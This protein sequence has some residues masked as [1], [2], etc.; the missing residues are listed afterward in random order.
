VAVE[1]ALSPRPA[2]AKEASPGR[3]WWIEPALTVASYSAFLIY[4]TWS[5]FDQVNVVFPPYVSPFFSLWLGFGLIRV[6]IIGILLPI[7]AVIP[8][9]LRGSC[10]YYRKSYFRSFFWDPPACAIQEL[11]RGKYRGETRFPWVLNNYH[12]YFLILS[13]IVI[14]FL[15]VDVVRAFT[16]HGHFFIGLGSLIMLANVILL[17]LYTFTCHS[18]RYL[19]GG[20]IDSFS[21][22]RFG[23]LWHRVVIVLNQLN[24]RHGFYAWVSMFSVALT[25]VY[26]R[27]L[28]AGIFH[29][30]RWIA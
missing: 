1:A 2:S 9:G 18:F 13:I 14:V 20:R 22:V 24:P 12:R 21:R 17:S 16:Y 3:T 23:R 4:A 7:L 29:E 5:V 27:L 19:M 15:T 26:V 6:P 10:Y 28:M 8:L 30:P 11:K 25:D